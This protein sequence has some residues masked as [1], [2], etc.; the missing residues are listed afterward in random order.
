MAMLNN[1]MVTLPSKSIIGFSNLMEANSPI[2][3]DPYNT[4][5]RIQLHVNGPVGKECSN[6]CYKSCSTI[7]Q[8]ICDQSQYPKKITDGTGMAIFCLQ[9]RL[10]DALHLLFQ[11]HLTNWQ[12]GFVLDVAGLI[13]PHILDQGWSGCRAPAMVWLQFSG[14]FVGSQEAIRV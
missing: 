4:D 5:E 7:G 10:L 6:V 3:R 11:N 2:F 14:R 13:P 8:F 9:I 12:I 1:Q